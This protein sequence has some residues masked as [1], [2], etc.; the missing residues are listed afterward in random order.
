MATSIIG[1]YFTEDT[2][3]SKSGS[4]SRWLFLASF[5]KRYVNNISSILELNT[6]ISCVKGDT[7]MFYHDEET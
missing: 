7:E 3:V 6:N 5:K 4:T 2:V 1:S